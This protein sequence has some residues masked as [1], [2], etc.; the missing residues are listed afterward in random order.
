MKYNSRQYAAAFYEAVRG[1]TA[2]E[3]QGAFDNLIAL[4]EKNRDTALAPKIAESFEQYA[5][6][7]EKIISGELVSAREMDGRLKSEIVEKMARK[8]QAGELYLKEKFD[9]NLIGGFK[10]KAGEFFL[11]AS[12]KGALMK[13]RRQVR[14]QVFAR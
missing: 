6:K 5:R 9:D 10:I 14:D 11:D 1:K 7:K 8:T 3:A 12:L 4:L 2:K 13:M